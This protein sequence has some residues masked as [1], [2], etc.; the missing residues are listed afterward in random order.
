MSKL[1]SWSAVTF[2]SLL[3]VSGEGIDVIQGIAY[4]YVLSTPFW[5]FPQLI[6]TI[7]SKL[8]SILFSFYSL[9]GVSSG[10]PMVKY[11]INDGYI[12]DLSTPFWE[13]L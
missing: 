8:F 9:L 11:I 6:S 10:F 13:F 7:F 5:E 12:V 2:Y 4:P 1:N 3:G